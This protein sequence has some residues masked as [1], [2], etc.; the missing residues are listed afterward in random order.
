[1]MLIIPRDM[2]TSTEKDLKI[3]SSVSLFHKWSMVR[4][5]FR[6]LSHISVFEVKQ[7]TESNHS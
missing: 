7:S 2:L 4:L 3:G 6:T 1:M 5:W